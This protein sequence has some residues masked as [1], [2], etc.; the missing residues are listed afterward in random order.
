MLDAA[1]RSSG[2]NVRSVKN[3]WLAADTLGVARKPGP[4][5]SGSGLPETE[6]QTMAL[7]RTQA[8]TI[9]TKEKGPAIRA[10]PVMWIGGICMGYLQALR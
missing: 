4:S 1:T 7:R 8:A 2:E 10:G 9:P 3:W 5:A 6:P